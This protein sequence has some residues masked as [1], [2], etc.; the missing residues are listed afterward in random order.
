VSLATNSRTLL[1]IRHTG[2]RFGVC[3]L[4]SAQQ[5]LAQQFARGDPVERFA[6]VGYSWQLGVPM[7][8]ETVVGAVCAIRAELTVA[9]HVLVVGSPQRILGDLRH[10]PVIWFQRAYWELRPADALIR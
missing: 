8:R 1:A 3:V 7:L 6:G 4:S 9:D 5:E 10:N 2:G